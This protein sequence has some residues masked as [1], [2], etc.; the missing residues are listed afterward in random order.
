MYPCRLE[1]NAWQV[2]ADHARPPNG[3]DIGRL[4]HRILCSH[5]SV[6]PQGM[7]HNIATE[8][9]VNSFHCEVTYV[10]ILKVDNMLA[11][12][13]ICTFINRD[14]LYSTKL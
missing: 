14:A 8:Q 12:M 1:S 4:L 11:S 5:R 7:K 2:F 9:I 3:D 10:G 13:A 6:R